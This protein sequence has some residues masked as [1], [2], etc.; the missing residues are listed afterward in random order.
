[1]PIA[2]QRAAR[3]NFSSEQALFVTA[4]ASTLGTQN[5]RQLRTNWRS[6]TLQTTSLDTATTASSNLPGQEVWI[7]ET[8]KR[9]TT[10]FCV[11]LGQNCQVV[12]P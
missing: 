11:D 3:G 9:L 4:W 12:L 6:S 1:M 5:V 10:L 2:C 8:A 7:R